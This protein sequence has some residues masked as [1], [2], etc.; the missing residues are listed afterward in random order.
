ML[1][2][3]QIIPITSSLFKVVALKVLSLD[4][5][6][7]VSLGNLLEMRMIRLYFRPTE[8]EILGVGSAICVSIQ[9]PGNS[10]VIFKFKNY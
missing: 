7:V 10:H 9:P 8:S 2:P 6:S 5:L 4:Q 1:V 3:T